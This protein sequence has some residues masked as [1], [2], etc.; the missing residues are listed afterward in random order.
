MGLTINMPRRIADECCKHDATCLMCGEMVG[1]V[2]PETGYCLACC[3]VSDTISDSV[4][5]MWNLLWA[6]AQ[7]GRLKGGRKL[8]LEIHPERGFAGLREII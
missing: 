3:K 1:M 4:V 5:A 7:Q 6:M 8:L 2:H